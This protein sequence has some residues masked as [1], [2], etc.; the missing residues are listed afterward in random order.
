MIAGKPI[1]ESLEVRP[2]VY[3]DIATGRLTVLTDDPKV[4][5]M[6][7]G[8]RCHAC[9]QSA[10]GVTVEEIREGDKAVGLKCMPRPG[11]ERNCY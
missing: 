4:F 1:A 10:E 5:L 3:R 9:A 7:R 11:I 2:T 8:E 6:V